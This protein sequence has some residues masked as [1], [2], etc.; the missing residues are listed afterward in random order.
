M[1]AEYIAKCVSAGLYNGTSFY[2]SDFVIQCGLYGSGKSNPYGDLPKNETFT[3]ARVNN[4]RGTAAIAHFDVP[5]NG[6][7]EVGPSF[8]S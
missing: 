4:T 3:G 7:T 5:D 8:G 2:R 1:T 6:N